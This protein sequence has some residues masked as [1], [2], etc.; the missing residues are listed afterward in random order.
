MRISD[1]AIVQLQLENV[2]SPGFYFFLGWHLF[3]SL[4]PSRIFLLPF[5][6]WIKFGCDH[7][8][9]QLQEQGPHRIV[10]GDAVYGVT[11]GSAIGA[12]AAVHLDVLLLATSDRSILARDPPRIPL[13]RTSICIE[14]RAAYRVR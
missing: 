1:L 2:A 9:R 8:I 6:R 11:R 12:C 5:L 7:T 14:R 4:I 3:L 13:H 10:F